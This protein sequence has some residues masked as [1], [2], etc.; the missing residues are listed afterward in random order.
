MEFFVSRNLV[1]IVGIGEKGGID[2]RILRTSLDQDGGV[3]DF[4]AKIS[5]DGYNP[6]SR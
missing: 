6:S 2:E 4:L 5:E 1:F 3:I